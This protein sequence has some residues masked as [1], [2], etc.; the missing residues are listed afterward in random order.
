[1][2]AGLQYGQAPRE[3]AAFY[4]G[5]GRGRHLLHPGSGE[6]SKLALLADHGW[7]RLTFVRSD[8]MKEWIFALLIF[9]VPIQIGNS[10]KGEHGTEDPFLS[11]EELA[12][13][14]YTLVT[15][16]T[17]QMPD[18]E[19]VRDLFAE[20]AIITLRLGPQTTR[21]FDRQAF[22]DYFIYDI[23]RANLLESGFTETV[24]KM[25]VQTVKDMA[26]GWAAYEVVVPG[27]NDNRPVNRGIDC[28]HFIKKEGRWRIA[29]VV[30]EG[31]RMNEPLPDFVGITE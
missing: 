14:L 22:I 28:F 1:L 25:H 16:E 5:P 13:E 12:K 17:G 18:W 23:E 7:G 15:F 21:T 3:F 31:F 2:A 19:R 26:F 9:L 29:S 6:A 4:A 8:S 27:R 24:L 11:P 20:G 30:N 10:G